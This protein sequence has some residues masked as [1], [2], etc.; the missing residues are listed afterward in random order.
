MNIRPSIIDAGYGIA[1]WSKI[2]AFYIII[3]VYSGFSLVKNCDLLE[4]RR[5]LTPFQ[6]QANHR[7]FRI[8]DSQWRALFCTFLSHKTN[9]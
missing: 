1:K 7:N 5:M 9:R 6:R 8:I 3:R 4:D 2:I